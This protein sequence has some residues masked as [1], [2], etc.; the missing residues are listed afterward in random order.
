MQ[1]VDADIWVLT[2]SHAQVSPGDT[3][4]LAARS[5]HAGATDADESWVAVWSRVDATP[6]STT[7]RDRT[8]AVEISIGSS[9]SAVVFGTV[10]PWLGSAW[11]NVPASNSAAFCASLAEQVT[12]WKRIRE[13][14]PRREL[15]IAGDFNQ[16]LLS[17][18]HYYGSK[19][20]R[21]AVRSALGTAMLSC[22]TSDPRD[23]VHRHTAGRAAGIDHIC[24]S[25]GLSAANAAVHVW[26]AP[27]ARGA[28]LSDH[29]GVCINV[30]AS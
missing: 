22:P 17:E 30:T 19:A 24:I 11:R 26:P 29:F 1:V 20:G 8:A 3:Y 4:H 12:D 16:D 13:D 27:E 10:L 5:G 21:A 14:D 18:G 2:E 28:T 25:A 7:D 9:R 6:V 23:A 15:C